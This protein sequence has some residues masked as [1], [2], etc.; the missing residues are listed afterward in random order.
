MI[1]GLVVGF[2]VTLVSALIPAVRATKIPPMAGLREG[3]TLPRGRFARYSPIFAVLFALAGAALIA[4]GVTGSG[5][6]S[7]G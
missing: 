2:G 6:A 1:L 7:R 3:A 5:Q 4:N